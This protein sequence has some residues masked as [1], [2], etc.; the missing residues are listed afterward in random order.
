VV[1]TLLRQALA[2]DPL[3]VHGDGTQT[4]CFTYID[5]TVRGTLAA[6]FTPEAEGRVFNLGST[7]E[8]SVRE[9]AELIRDSVGSSSEIALTSYES[10]YGPGFEDTRRRVPDI[11]RA[12]EMLNWEPEIPLEDGLVRTIK[13]WKEA[14]A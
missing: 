2:G 12:R 8:T 9:L 11:T 1:A 7:R 13:W 6:A 10:Y 4:R 5:D 3:T 14:H